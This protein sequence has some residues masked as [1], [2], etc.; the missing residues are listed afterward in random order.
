LEVEE[1]LRRKASPQRFGIKDR[2]VWL[3]NLEQRQRELFKP[4]VIPQ[5]WETNYVQVL[6]EFDSHPQGEKP[7]YI[8]A[9]LIVPD[10]DADILTAYKEIKMAIAYSFAEKVANSLP[11]YRTAP[12][13]Q[14]SQPYHLFKRKA[15]E[16]WRPF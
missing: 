3:F 7:L 14:F 6:V 9:C 15:R 4:V 5:G 12:V 13:Q 2:K 10:R 8:Q 1:W 16:D 11:G